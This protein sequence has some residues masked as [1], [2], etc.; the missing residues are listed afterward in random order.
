MAL[1]VVH[2]LVKLAN[3]LVFKGVNVMTFD[4]IKVLVSKKYEIES[5]REISHGNQIK[6]KNG[7]VII[8]YF[9]GTVQ[10]Q[11]NPKF[12]N[13]VEAYVT[14]ECNA[15]PFDTSLSEQTR[16]NKVFVVYGHDESCRDALEAMLRRWSL[17][18]IILDSLASEGKTIIEKLEAYGNTVRYA[19]ILATPDDE[20]YRRGLPGEKMFRV[21]QN[22]VLELGMFLAKLGRERVAILLKNPKEIERPSDIQGL[23]YIPFENNPKETSPILAREIQKCLGI[24]IDASKL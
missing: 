15:A 6:L 1:V 12:K 2:L 14:C 18:P 13:E 3:N 17:E 23:V 4:Q 8:V 20:G 24:P 21:R 10:Y 19:I 9:K 22:V 7:V 11:G 5:E 16:N